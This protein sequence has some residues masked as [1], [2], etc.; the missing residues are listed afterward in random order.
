MTADPRLES[1]LRGMKSCMCGRR[2]Q[3]HLKGAT[4]KAAAIACM[5]TG[6]VA[7]GSSAFAQ[8]TVSPGLDEGPAATVRRSDEGPLRIAARREAL[9]LAQSALQVPQSKERWIVRHPVLTGTLIGT[10]IGAGLS[11]VDAI[12]GVNH[13]PK[14]A[15]LGAGAGAWA[16]LVA[17]AV[18][19]AR[20]RQKVGAGTKAGIVAGA[21]ALIVLPIVACYGAG[22]CG[23]SS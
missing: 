20:S 2:I 23:G 22:G 14:V 8:S 10:G 4:R 7:C 5:V 1:L 13:D 9:R 16:G 21:V 17:S 3:R 6:L 19:K 15:L 11:R 18:H 12:G